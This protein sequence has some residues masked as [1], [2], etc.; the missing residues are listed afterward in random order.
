MFYPFM[1]IIS[2]I[3]EMFPEFLNMEGQLAN[4]NIPRRVTKQRELQM[5]FGIADDGKERKRSAQKGKKRGKKSDDE[6][7]DD[8]DDDKETDDELEHEEGGEGTDSRTHRKE[9]LRQKEQARID[10]LRAEAVDA[11]KI[12]NSGTKL[13]SVK[14]YNLYQP[15]SRESS[16]STDAVDQA[17]RGQNLISFHTYE[18]SA[19]TSG[20][21]ARRMRVL[22]CIAI[23]E[24]T[25]INAY[26]IGLLDDDRG[27]AAAIRLA[28]QDNTEKYRVVR[29]TSRKKLSK[30]TLE[31]AGTAVQLTPDHVNLTWPDHIHDVVVPQVDF[32]LEVEL[33]SHKR[34]FLRVSQAHQAQNII[35]L[36]QNSRIAWE[37]TTGVVE[38]RDCPPLRPQVQDALEVLIKVSRIAYDNIMS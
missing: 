15:R 27:G 38:L 23:L 19:T 22:A 33:R 34:D 7:D 24:Q 5:V 25:V 1:Q 20:S 28:I 31:G 21:R 2:S 29:P 18:W 16:I 13:T 17:F 12:L 35:N 14:H 30:L 26:R 36:V 6:D 32:D 9:R 11:Q 37:D 8:D 4:I 3:F 10:N